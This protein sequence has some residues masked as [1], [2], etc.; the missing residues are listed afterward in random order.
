MKKEPLFLDR[1]ILND[2][3]NKKSLIYLDDIKYTLKK[4]NLIDKKTKIKKKELLEKLKIHYSTNRHYEKHI[5]KI[6]FIQKT[7][8][9]KLTNK[10]E[11]FYSKFTNSEDFYTLESIKT[12]DKEKLFWYTD[13]KK[14]TFAFDIY[15]FQQLIIKKCNN[16]Y[17][18]DDIP[19]YAIE[20]FNKQLTKLNKKKIK[21]SKEDDILT[22]QQQ[23]NSKII[24]I[25]QKLEELDVVA[26]GINHQWFMNF[27]FFQ[28]KNVYKVLED[29]WNYR[30]EISIE[31]KNKIVP[32]NNIFKYGVNYINNMVFS[33]YNFYYLLNIILNEITTIITSGID[34]ENKKLGGYYV[35]ITLTE[36]S[37]DYANSYPWLK[38]Y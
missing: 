20:Q 7:Y 5:N 32:N 2:K 36:V 15:S 30:S 21:F 37:V 38:Q 23:L 13:E 9:Q 19:T 31:Q 22:N 10:E 6:I 33:N 16:P 18:R 3:L 34:L 8:K 28:L 35:L 25:F 1:T 24:S 17:N 26:G 27:S 29:V 12:I 11:N 4:L 14:F